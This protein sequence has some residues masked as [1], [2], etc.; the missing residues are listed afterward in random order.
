MKHH[1]NHAA[2]AMV[3]FLFTAC[4][5]TASSQDAA[6]SDSTA[7]AT[8]QTNAPAE[9]ILTEEGLPPVVIGA[10]INDLPESVEGLYASKKYHQIDPN[11]SDEEI[12]WDEVEGWYFYD[13]DGELLFTAEDNQGAI[14]RVIVK[15]PTIKTAQGAH[16]G[17]SRDQV[18]AIEGAKLIKPHPDA[19]YEI[20]SIE[21]GKISMTL[22]AVNA[23]EVVDMMVFDYSAFE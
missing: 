6:G 23:Q 9:P 4:S 21:L 18:L 14:Y 8:E 2:A 5:N 20:Y 13:K 7:V 22:D 3:A 15:S 17:M 10:N 11:L 1:L 19:D 16:I 12:G